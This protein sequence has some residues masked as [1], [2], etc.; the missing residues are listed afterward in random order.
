MPVTLVSLH[1]SERHL[2]AVS[3][4][5]WQMKLKSK[6]VVWPAAGEARSDRS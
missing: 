1:T 3:A 6:F 5:A 4:N 2:A